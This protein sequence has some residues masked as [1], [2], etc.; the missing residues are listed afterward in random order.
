[1]RGTKGGEKTVSN[2]LPGDWLRLAVPVHM[3]RRI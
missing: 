3:I 2:V 1:M